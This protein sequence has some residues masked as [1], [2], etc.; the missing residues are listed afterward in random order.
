VANKKQVSV[1]VQK[2]NIQK[3]LRLF[4]RKIE[5]SGHLQLLREKQTYT[6]PTTV[7]RREK[8][9]AVRAQN[10]LTLL[11]KIEGGDTSIRI[12]EKKKKK[13]SRRK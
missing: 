12:F 7:R 6:K 9:L 5:D 11:E 4:K 2:G 10:K 3:A 8:Q 13:G 1:Q